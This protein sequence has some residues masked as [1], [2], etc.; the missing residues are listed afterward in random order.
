VSTRGI[1]TLRIALVILLV[2]WFFSPPSWRYAVPLWLPFLVALAV[3]VE[4]AVGGFV[5]TARALPRERSRAPQQVDLERFGWREEEPEDDDPAFWASP[6]VP[7][8]RS[9]WRRRVAASVVVLA[10][11]AL[12]AWGVSVRRGWSSL[13]G[14]TQARFERVLSQQASR[15][16]GHPAT[17]VCDTKG[18]HVGAVQESDGLAEVGG[19]IAWLTPGNCYRLYRVLDHRDTSSFGPTGRAIAVL[20]HEAWHLKGVADEGLA[21]CYAFQSGVEIGRRLGLSDGRARS[22]MRAQ[23]A[24]NA[25]DSAA[26]PRYLVPSGCRDGGRYD[27]HPRSSRFT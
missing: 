23:L 15:I 12:V 9:T 21:N 27:L 25:A 18:R 20:G 4:F 5:R 7:R 3:E 24:D 17:I 8:A 16:A 10:F 2:A 13:D 22:L 19:G 6:P 26:D 14:A 1:R 11:V